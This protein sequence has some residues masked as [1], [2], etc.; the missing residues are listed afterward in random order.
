MS[1]ETVREEQNATMREERNAAETIR[2]GQTSIG[3]GGIGVGSVFQGYCV[4]RQLPTKGSEADIFVGE[5]DAAQYILKLYRYGIK[6][7]KDILLTIK[8]L[9]ESYPQEF[10]QA[11]A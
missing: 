10:V 6:P 2:E 1:D 4:V 7:K 5:K 8:A 11:P 3:S 9:S